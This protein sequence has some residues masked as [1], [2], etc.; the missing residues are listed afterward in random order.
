MSEP[1]PDPNTEF[2]FREP[3]MNIEEGDDSETGDDVA[4]GGESD[5]ESD[6]EMDMVADNVP[7]GAKEDGGCDQ[8]SLGHGHFTFHLIASLLL[9]IF[10]LRR[11]RPVVDLLAGKSLT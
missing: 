11:R 10:A 8:S 5:D 2:D 1:L 6:R 9:A 4:G 3:P 7:A